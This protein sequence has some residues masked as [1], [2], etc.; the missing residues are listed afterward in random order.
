MPVSRGWPLLFAVALVT[1]ARTLRE[2]L[3]YA[4]GHWLQ[5]YREGFLPRG[6]PGT[7]LAP[8]FGLKSPA[9]IQF[10]VTAVSL[11]VFVA[12]LGAFAR[13]SA[14]LLAVRGPM[15]LPSLLLA[16]AAATSAWVVMAGLLCGYYDH[17]VEL[18]VLGAAAAVGTRWRRWAPVLLSVAMLVH[19]LTVVLVPAVVALSWVGERERRGREVALLVVPPGLVFVALAVAAHGV[20]AEQVRAVAQAVRAPGVLDSLEAEHAVAHLRV[21]LDARYFDVAPM[22]VPALLRPDIALVTFPLVTLLVTAA[23]VRVGR[24]AWVFPVAALAPLLLYT[25]ATDTARFAYTTI[26][27]ATVLL[28]K[29]SREPS[30]ERPWFARLLGGGAALVICVNLGA[31]V[32]LLA[33]ADDGAAAL[34]PRSSPTS[35]SFDHCRAVF[36]GAD[37]EDRQLSGWTVEGSFH[38]E[39]TEGP[40][41]AVRGARGDGWANSGPPEATGR[42]VSPEFEVERTMLFAVAGGGGGAAVVLEVDGHAVREAT[43]E[44][45]DEL[46][47]RRWDTTPWLGRTGRIVVRDESTTTSL[48]VDGFCWYGAAPLA[49]AKAGLPR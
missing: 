3:P 1:S 31:R 44:R 30:P 7:L 37:M 39:A 21:H 8:L 4:V 20:T 46:T 32:P 40:R 45:P 5:S 33:Q 27:V 49:P 42:M 25:T 41:G 47:L 23:C 29:V 19:E 24:R 26:F 14:P 38:H 35:A 2:P 16:V 22:V 11:A 28:A 15:R 17:L 9:E 6:L 36:G 12:L 34:W 13:F 18:A 43:G 48:G 10:A